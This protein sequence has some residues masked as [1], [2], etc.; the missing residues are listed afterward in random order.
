MGTYM[1]GFFEVKLN[2]V[3]HS[4]AELN[5]SSGLIT[6]YWVMAGYNLFHDVDYTKQHLKPISKPRGVPKDA[7]ELVKYEA[8]RYETGDGAEI[9][10]WL[11]KE[12]MKKVYSILAD[13]KAQ[14]FDQNPDFLWQ[15]YRYTNYDRPNYNSPYED[16]RLIIWFSY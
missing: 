12:E 6:V 8:K 7:S 9:F 2:G 13:K 11:S 3:W 5:G 15:I 16:I 10:T 4:Y 14:P 1:H